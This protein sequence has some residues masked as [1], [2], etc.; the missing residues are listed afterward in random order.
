[1]DMTT[2]TIARL[3]LTIRAQQT[4]IDGLQAANRERVSNRMKEDF[5][6]CKA[7]L[8]RLKADLD[9]ANSSL[10]VEQGIS[11]DLAQENASLKQTLSITSAALQDVKANHGSSA[12]SRASRVM[13]TMAET[14]VKFFSDTINHGVLADAGSAVVEAVVEEF[15]EDGGGGGFCTKD[16]LMQ[17]VGGLKM[18]SLL[19]GQ[20]EKAGRALSETK[21]SERLW[22]RIGK[23]EKDLAAVLKEQKKFET[24]IHAVNVEFSRL[25]HALLDF[26][27]QRVQRAPEILEYGEKM[28]AEMRRLTR[29][30]RS[31]KPVGV[32][33]YAGI[34]YGHYTR[35][36]EKYRE[37]ITTAGAK[38]HAQQQQAS[39]GKKR[40]REQQK[41][42]EGGDY[43]DDDRGYRCYSDIDNGGDDGSSSHSDDG[44]DD[45]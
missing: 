21:G 28:E 17:T 24:T 33:D 20:L 9:E 22:T 42:E 23:L 11:K 14:V 8:V 16:M 36:V 3:E 13:E 12:L 25:K 18:K 6:A 26:D 44:N 41:Q 10:K 45:P 30:S 32:T 35:N 27:D 38:Q 15:C 39:G 19:Q 43:N 29:T 40:R 7:E 2:A 31:G 37:M 5:K 1:M 34:I 4:E